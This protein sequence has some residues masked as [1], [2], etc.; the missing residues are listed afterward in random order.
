MRLF[1]L[2]VAAVCGVA[3]GG[4]AGGP[5]L[6][7]LRQL[8]DFTR[9]GAP[10]PG[11]QQ[12]P[13]VA[14][15]PNRLSLVNEVSPVWGPRAGGTAVTITGSGIAPNATVMFCGK[16]AVSTEVKGTSTIIAVTPPMSVKANCNVQVD[17][18]DGDSVILV[19]VY[20]F[21]GE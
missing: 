4:G 15:R 9:I 18:H 14:P 2:V 6:P 21:M 1:C 16:H 8:P 12:Q 10:P 3:C 5:Q 11:Q 17:N 20:R 7:D 13:P 19:Q